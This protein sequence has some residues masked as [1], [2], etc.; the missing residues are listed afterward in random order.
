MALTAANTLTKTQVQERTFIHKVFNW[1]ALALGITGVVAFVTVN[2]PPVINFIAG[3]SLVFFGLIIAEL[4]LVIY[5]SAK[6][7]T[8]DA[9]TALRAFLAYAFLNGLTLSVIFLAY[10]YESIAITF[11][12]TAG[13]FSAMSFYGYTTK[14]DLTSWGNLAIMSLIGIII[15]TIVNIFLKST[16]LYWFISYAG[17][18]IFVAL[19]AYDTQ[20]LK[21]MSHN[22][23]MEEESTTKLAVFGALALYLDFIN[24][25][26]FLLRIF[27]G[28]RN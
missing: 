8:M 26:L 23:N 6:L 27:G 11:F 3:N 4:G 5:L 22:L 2:T 16:F 24:L 25:F 17:V 20:K 12:I 14:Q 28:R 15:A 18:A 1:M 19:T 13:T 10:T 9:T 7:Q 21:R